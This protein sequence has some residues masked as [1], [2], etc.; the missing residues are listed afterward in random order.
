[1]RLVFIIERD[2]ERETLFSV[3]YGLRLKKELTI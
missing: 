3:K 2:R 1:M